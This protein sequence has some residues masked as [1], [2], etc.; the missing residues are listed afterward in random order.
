MVGGATRWRLHKDGVAHSRR[1]F[2]QRRVKWLHLWK[3]C[4]YS[5]LRPLI[6]PELSSK[7]ASATGST[8]GRAAPQSPWRHRAKE[9]DPD[10]SSFHHV[11]TDTTYLDSTLAFNLPRGNIF[12]PLQAGLLLFTYYRRQPEHETALRLAPKRISPILSA[13]KPSRCIAKSAASR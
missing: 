10:T 1:D 8:A 7:C 11:P 5:A 12:F 3:S 13:T 9:R 2:V 4:N 6:T